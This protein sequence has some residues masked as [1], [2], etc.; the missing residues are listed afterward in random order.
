[1]SSFEFPVNDYIRKLDKVYEEHLDDNVALDSVEA[2]N[3]T[4]S[5]DSCELIGS[6]TSCLLGSSRALVQTLELNAELDLN[7]Q[8][9]DAVQEVPTV[10]SAALSVDT[11]T[12]SDVNVL[13]PVLQ[14]S[15]LDPMDLEKEDFSEQTID[16]ELVSNRITDNINDDIRPTDNIDKENGNADDHVESEV[17]KSSYCCTN[18][19]QG[20]SSLTRFNIH[21]Q[22]CRRYECDICHCTLRDKKGLLEHIRRIHETKFQCYECNDIFNTE[23]RLFRH[24]EKKHNAEKV[25]PNCKAKSKNIRAL[26]KHIKHNCKSKN[27][28]N[29]FSNNKESINDSIHQDLGSTK[30]ASLPWNCSR[31][32]L[33]VDKCG[34]VDSKKILSVAVSS[35]Q[36]GALYIEEGGSP[37][38][39]IE[40]VE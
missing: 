5:F 13:P 8:S 31:C 27:T 12:S 24:F 19:K 10:D 30:T 1:M 16:P 9:S 33:S 3:V 11:I 20:F 38:I 34:H 7:L 37:N 35:D 29:R 23:K 26:R 21:I 2:P 14:S 40:L 22:K 25:C 32:N 28:N 6:G 36:S 39:I 15:N 18:C 4:D 17:S